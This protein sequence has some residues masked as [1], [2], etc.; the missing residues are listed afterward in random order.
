MFIMPK[1][2]LTALWIYDGVD[3]MT[4]YGHILG[5]LSSST[6]LEAENVVSGDAYVEHHTHTLVCQ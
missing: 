6:Q 4:Q 1:W 3:E 2:R 5:K